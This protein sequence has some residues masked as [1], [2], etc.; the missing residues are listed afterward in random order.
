[1]KILKFVNDI[2]KFDLV[3]F[4]Q[5]ERVIVT[6]VALFVTFVNS[7]MGV[8]SSFDSKNYLL[9]WTELMIFICST[10]LLI[11]LRLK[12]DRL[13]K[14]LS[15]ALLGAVYLFLVATGGVFNNGY[16]W[17]FAFPI[18]AFFV[19]GLRAGTISTATFLIVLIS[20]FLLEKQV[21][22]FVSHS[23]MFKIWFVGSFMAVFVTS[24]L[25][26]KARYK[27]Q[28]ELSD[29]NNS[30][31]SALL[32]LKYN[33]E[34]FRFLSTSS[35]ALM[36]L[37]TVSEIYEYIISNFEKLSPGS[38]IIV[39]FVEE[40]KYLKV[41]EISGIDKKLRYEIEEILG[42][43]IIGS[44]FLLSNEMKTLLRS[45]KINKHF[46][47]FEELVTGDLS[48]NA[49]HSIQ[50]L[51]VIRN[52]YSIGLNYKDKLFG[53]IHILTNQ[54]CDLPNQDV[55]EVF[56][57]QVSAVLQKKQAEDSLLSQIYFQEALLNAI[58][59]AIFYNDSQLRYLGCNRAF[60]EL[61][62]MNATNIIGKTVQDIWDT[63]HGA[64]HNEKNKLAI[65]TGVTQIYEGQIKNTSGVLKNLVIRKAIFRKADG[66]IGGIIGSVD[67][68]TEVMAAKEAAESANRA[69]GQF[70]A[71]MSHEIRT[72]LNGVIGMS[73]LLLT[74][75]LDK[76]QYEYASTI[77]TSANAL[78]TVLND[79][80]DFS[81][82]EVDKIVLDS[83]PFN[84]NKIVKDV[85]LINAFQLKTKKITFTSSIDPSVP[86]LISGDPGRLRQVLLN[87]VGNAVKFTN[88]GSVG[89]HVF[90][91][92]IESTKILLRF[93]ITD[94]GIGIE[95]QMIP[96]LFQPFMQADQS[97]SRTYGGSG[98]GL[99]ISKRFVEMMNGTIGVQ[100]S[101][102]K[103]SLFYFTAQFLI[104]TSSLL[105][106]QENLSP[107]IPQS[108]DSG[109][110]SETILV[111]EDNEINTNV[112]KLMLQKLGFSVVTAE[113]GEKGIIFL[114]QQ[115]FGLV[116]MDLH[117]PK[118][119]GFRAAEIIR[120]G[121]A[122][123]K[124]TNI[125]IVAVT[126]TVLEEDLAGCEQVGINSYLIKPVQYDQL[127]LMVNKFLPKKQ[128]LTSVSAPI[129]IATGSKNIFD[130]EFAL[131]NLADDDSIFR[132]AL[133]LFMKKMPEYIQ[134]LQDAIACADVKQIAVWAHTFKGAARTIGAIELGDILEAIE[135]DAHNE[136][137]STDN[138]S[139]IEKAVS[140]FQN[141]VDFTLKS[142][143]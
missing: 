133:L 108:F 19:L 71:N 49:I 79:V 42:Y 7:L 1:V 107:Q 34:Q 72:P 22:F 59:N 141:E 13:I 86:H 112:I 123:K 46:G 6:Y 39:N 53:G 85:E 29:K 40:D 128:L 122:G 93:E 2:F 99:T 109:D 44:R 57:Q 64:L 129:S 9:F 61:V 118:L 25:Y 38:V 143:S 138:H 120:S 113:D 28:K 100:S 75:I 127:H 52:V 63:E 3:S 135:R 24:L 60:E 21:S 32:N 62:G 136:I 17:T 35:V 37:S 132:D 125:P 69:K 14:Y 48:D 15:I 131:K 139:I 67:D 65:E 115:D 41:Y 18:V 102:G 73:E 83:I 117:M 103:G 121:G 80:L 137:T 58:P 10:I 5:R 8:V 78:L 56:F 95:K 130:K 27:N 116:L 70:L 110:N 23:L 101:V 55:I 140:V 11:R 134:K 97:V 12:L 66:T 47:G 43:Q 16:L 89:L 124:N 90:L 91:Q 45:G 33:E 74:T 92:N 31:E 114:K 54:D 94:T 4:D 26:E 77:M 104:P 87:L 81:K 105:V 88:A 82:L 30:L 36:S 98:L 106:P 20:I 76:E 68:I 50:E 126:A 111:V 51:S 84:L 119:D 96:L 142:Y